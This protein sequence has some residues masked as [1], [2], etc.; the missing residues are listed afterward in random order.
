M[1]KNNRSKIAFFVP[2]LMGGGAE[3]AILN[4]A[5]EFGGKGV[6]EKTDLVLVKKEGVYLAEVRSEVNVVD[7]KSGNVPRSLFRLIKYLRRE[8][9]DVLVS[10]LTH[11]SALT[12][13]AKML[14]RSKTKI[15]IR[16][17]NTFSE[18][19]KNLGFF[20]RKILFYGV[21]FTFPFADEIV[22]VSGGVADDLA[23][24]I[25]FPREKISV[26]FN[27]VDLKKIEKKCQEP[28]NHPWLRNKTF[29]I[30]LAVGR[31]TVEKDYPTLL[32]AFSIAVKQKDLRLI[33]LGE[34]KKRRELEEMIVKMGLQNKIDMPGFVGNPYV[35]MS[36]CDLY[37]LS[38][39]TE[40]MPNTMIE[41]MACGMP[42]ASTDCPSGPREVLDDGKYGK[43][44]KVG[45]E[46]ALAEAILNTLKNP[47]NVL[48]TKKRIKEKFY[49]EKGAEKYLNIIQKYLDT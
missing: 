39:K 33:I 23:R 5:N 19:L 15:I 12:V 21:K 6:F 43:L 49:L 48:K 30:L 18:V 11:A 29:P 44:V 34:G 24:E 22:A 38:S 4:I 35:F 9:P 16:L 1:Q 8:K 27:S 46:N 42:V 28:A 20:D 25:N 2:S 14:A 10:T 40:G 37:V 47:P 32:R 45:D 3:R 26:V 7:L 31:L 41:A 36:R 17:A 13:L